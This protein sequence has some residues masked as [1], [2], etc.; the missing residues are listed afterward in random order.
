L[1]RRRALGTL[2]GGTAAAAFL[3]AC[4]GDG[5]DEPGSSSGTGSPATSTGATGGTA[6][7]GAT[8]GSSGPSS[9]A[10]ADPGTPKRGGTLTMP[11]RT[12]PVHLDL[13]FVSLYAINTVWGQVYNNLFKMTAGADVAPN[14]A[15][16]EADL[17]GTWE[18]PDELTYIYKLSDKPVK[19][20]D[21]DPVNGRE[22]DAEDIVFSIERRLN[23]TIPQIVRP[24]FVTS[25]DSV[26]AV[27]KKTVRFK[28]N[29]PDAIL[30]STLSD[31]SWGIVPREIVEADG[32]MRQRAIGTG[33]FLLDNWN[34]GVSITLKKNPDY[35]DEG[36]P[37]LDEM[38]FLIMGDYS[39]QQG[40][41]VTG[42]L[43]VISQ[44]EDPIQAEE[45]AAQ[46]KDA[47]VEEWITRGL[48]YGYKI[49]GR[50]D[51][52]TDMRVR[53]AIGAAYN[54]ELSIQTVYGGSAVTST[55]YPPAWVAGQPDWQVPP[56]DLGPAYTYSP[57]EA[58][59]L[60]EA[61]DRLDVEV[62]VVVSG[63]GHGP[64]SSAN[65]AFLTEN[66]S[67]GGFKASLYDAPYP[68]Y[69][70]RFG[71]NADGNY[72]I[73][74]AAHGT[75]W[76]VADAYLT[77]VNYAITGTGNNDRQFDP[78]LIDMSLQYRTL[79]D[80]EERKQHGFEIQKYHAEQANYI[81]AEANLYRDFWRP[82][83][84]NYRPASLWT[85]GW[86]SKVLREVWL[87]P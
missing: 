35:W 38:R 69:A 17:P 29:Q 60:L 9:S 71:F 50:V 70:A 75:T 86:G 47:L 18:Q 82:Y 1:S 83:V 55:P 27:D 64:Q 81:A 31:Y 56:E 10:A 48:T 63:A 4:G 14:G 36:K 53:Q 54:R 34:K 78:K 41:F 16:V 37:Y 80:D 32:D 28:L 85:L 3:T 12:E 45:V 66:L 87:D 52:L 13:A 42:E 20:H 6:S 25:V 73:M 49:N 5:D 40:Q 7:T 72:D 74:R 43:D 67:K 22:L 26:E 84:K 51:R 21:V 61:A 11:V 30:Q 65:G 2:A 77:Q 24:V 15:V 33:P 23:P 68:E 39:T 19:F 57:E 58:R 62:Q 79:L 76:D 59:K 44:I 46:V 8:G